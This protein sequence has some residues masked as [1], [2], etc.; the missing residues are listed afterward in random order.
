MG[1][2]EK[3][4]QNLEDAGCNSEIIEEFFA[5]L[6]QNDIEKI[7]I[8]LAKHRKTLLEQ[9]HQSQREVDILDY[10]IVDLERTNNQ[11]GWKK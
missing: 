8:L 4:Q 11:K 5:L 2:K 9:M 6:E 3:L 1:D 7:L 10:L